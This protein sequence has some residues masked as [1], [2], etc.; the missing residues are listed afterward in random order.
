MANKIFQ[1]LAKEKIDLFKRAFDESKELFWDET[2]SK[3]IHPGEF[4]VYREA[5]V[6]DFLSIFIPSRYSI[7][8][9]FIINTN[10][11]ISTQCDLVIYDHQSTPLMQSI[12]HQIFYPIETVVAVGEIKSNIES[13]VALIDA[14]TKLAKIKEMREGIGQNLFIRPEREGDYDPV[15]F[16]FD[17]LFTF[18]ICNKFGFEIQNKDDN[19]F[20]IYPPEIPPRHKHNILFSINDG[21][22][23]YHNGRSNYYYPVTDVKIEKEKFIKPDNKGIESHFLHLISG[24]LIGVKTSSILSPDMAKYLS[25][26][27]YTG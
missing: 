1:E 5:I 19:T 11:I 25:D 17:Q 20:D 24:L 10:G 22:Y 23:I 14:L 21:I 27:L 2:K 26:N 4:G 12:N 15:H 9:G 8:S 3:L 7:G 16:S 13:K 6:K 18:L